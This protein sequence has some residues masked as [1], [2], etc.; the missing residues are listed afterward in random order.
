M[1]YGS[2]LK[3]F[4]LGL[5]PRQKLRI[6]AKLADGTLQTVINITVIPVRNA[7]SAQKI[8]MNRLER[9]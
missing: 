6:S 9:G 3:G 8:V 5:M 7:S 4:L 2:V 1:I